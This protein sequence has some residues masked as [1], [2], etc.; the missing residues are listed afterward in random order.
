VYT[1]KKH[2]FYILF[3]NSRLPIRVEL[4]GLKK[5]ELYKILT[6]P[7]VNLIKQQKMLL[8]TE[9]VDLI[10]EDEA[11]HEIASIA[12]EMNHTVENIG[13]RRLHTVMERIME[14]ISFNADEKSGETITIDKELVQ[15]RV[16]D[17]LKKQDLTRFIL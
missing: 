1:T 13:A 10:F 7:E 2:S 16:G 4:Q 11:V 12:A 8:N 17:M 3:S 9:G 15:E 14:E 5:P 6:E